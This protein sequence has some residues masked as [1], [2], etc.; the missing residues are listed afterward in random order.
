MRKINGRWKQRLKKVAIFLS[1]G[2]LANWA[3]AG[4]DPLAGTISETVTPA[5]G[6]GS[7]VYRLILLAEIFVGLF[8]IIKTRSFIAVLGVVVV[9]LFFNAAYSH[10]V[11]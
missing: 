4:S 6:T 5:L 1:L 8:T 10:Y 9:A 2:L 11:G 3:T 7:E